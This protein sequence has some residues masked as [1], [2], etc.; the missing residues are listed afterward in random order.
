VGR[1][2]PEEIS[3]ILKG[4]ITDY[5]SRTRTEE[6]GQVLQVG[7]GIAQ[8]HGLSNAMYQEMLEFEDN[9]GETVTGI[10]LSLEEDNVGVVIVGEDRHI[11]EGST[12]RRTGRRASS[13]V[14]KGRGGSVG[15][16]LGSGMV[17]RGGFG[18]N[19][20]RHVEQIASGV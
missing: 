4:A 17:G 16:A 19:E 5:E 1:L 18:A 11:R 14:G 8:V 3:S 12:V 2:R 10:A 20:T 9:R 13:R 7:D 6:V 15:D